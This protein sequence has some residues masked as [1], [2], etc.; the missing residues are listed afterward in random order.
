M[1]VRIRR[2]LATTAAGVLLAAASV[3]TA[4]ADD[5]VNDIVNP[6]ESMSLVIG[7]AI[8][9]TTLSVTT[10]NG[11][12]K[13]GCNLTGS[14]TA[15]FAINTSDAAVATVSPASVT[16]ASCGDVK[17]VTIT[18]HAPGEATV[19]LSQT[20][21]TTGATFNLAPA[22][23]A[24]HVAAPP[25]T[26]TPPVVTV[27]GFTDGDIF[28][29]G[30]H[31]LPTPGC[32]VQ[33]AE[34]VGESASPSITSGLDA[35]GLGTVEVT[36]SYTDT[37]KM[38]ASDSASYTVVDTGAPVI[39]DLGPTPKPD[40][41]NGWYVSPVTNTFRAT[42][43]G[44]GFETLAPKLLSY[45]FTG[46]TGTAQ[47]ADLTVRSGSVT[48]VAGNVAESIDSAAFDVDLTDPELNVSGPADQASFDMCAA[49]NPTR[50]TF[51]P[52]DRVSG[53]DEELTGD[54]WSSPTTA[55]GVGAYTYTATAFDHAG[56]SATETRTY[57]SQYGSA[58]AGVQ[59]PINGGTTE[60]LA[61][62]NSRFKLG[63][64]VPVKFKLVCGTAPI[65]NAVAKLNVKKS[66]GTP[67]PGTEEAASTA[68]ST[69]GN[70]FRYDSTSGQYVFNLSTRSGYTN[71]NGTTVS[72]AAGTYT[73]SI[74]LD[75][76]TFRSVNIQLVK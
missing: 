50:P 42:D 9:S 6:T 57:T 51:D 52:T 67:D 15:T 64:T 60:S 5:I 1:H 29:L 34:D 26:N 11:D 27:A 59:Q 71:T 66:D 25:P 3:G 68:A 36:C 28:E 23:F 56:R 48:D 58:F 32:S 44:A 54:T 41:K 2:A 37:G 46:S 24:V 76:G 47:G 74:M 13:N 4:Y 53:L 31:E 14:T 49:G 40:G 65:D 61:D 10:T 12:G 72:L 55:S 19:S 8:G 45:D 33:D 43:S 7:G 35:Y 75:D 69:S 30:V 62:D 38:G 21:N 18:P 16:F 39:T 22:T 70:L 73:L 17:T 63:S 20:S